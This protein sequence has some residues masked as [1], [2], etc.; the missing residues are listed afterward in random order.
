[1]RPGTFLIALDMKGEVCSSEQMAGVLGRLALEGRG[2]ITFVI[3]GSLGLSR[4]ILNR[5]NLRLSFFQIHFP[6]PV[7]ASDITGAALPL[8]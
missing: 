6:A 2:D 8:V 3:G 1:M 4:N 5:A 7:D